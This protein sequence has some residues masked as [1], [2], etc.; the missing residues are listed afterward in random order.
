[1]RYLVVAF[2]SSEACPLFFLRKI[3]LSL[4][5]IWGKCVR[6]WNSHTLPHLELQDRGKG[7]YSVP[8]CSVSL[9]LFSAVVKNH[10][11]LRS[12]VMWSPCLL[13]RQRTLPDVMC[14][15]PCEPSAQPSCH[16]IWT[17]MPGKEGGTD[18]GTCWSHYLCG[19]ACPLLLYLSHFICWCVIT[20]NWQGDH[21]HWRSLTA[22]RHLCFPPAETCFWRKFSEL[23]QRMAE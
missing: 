18:C 12:A 22:A 19:C 17:D 20:P 8:L 9:R 6:A 7:F 11:A 4:S 15:P 5:Y 14:G 3:K 13:W 10:L 1:M 16:N 21:Q 2:I 23:F